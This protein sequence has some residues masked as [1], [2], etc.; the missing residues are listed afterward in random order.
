MS[1]KQVN[2]VEPPAEF[3][4]RYEDRRYATLNEWGDVAG[5]Y[6][7]VEESV[8]VVVK[9][10]LKGVWL[11][12]ALLHS[13]GLALTFGCK[14]RFVLRDARK[15]YACPTKA[16]ALAS[17]LARKQRQAQILSTQLRD[18]KAAIAKAQVLQCRLESAETKPQELDLLAS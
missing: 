12:H 4:Y 18:V 13:S 5:T 7:Q 9:T 1:E 11:Q 2:G 15:R 3:W 16:E 10:T 8:F 14:P 17:F 6:S